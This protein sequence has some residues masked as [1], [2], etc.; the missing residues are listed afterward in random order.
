LKQMFDRFGFS[1]DA[2]ATRAR[3]IYLAQ[4]GYISMKTYEPLALRMR[5]IPEYLRIFTG[6]E[7]EA[8]EL[9]RFYQRN[10]FVPPAN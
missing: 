9:E 5:F 3:S 8:H 4:I 6:V 10:G 1:E 7:P 2:A